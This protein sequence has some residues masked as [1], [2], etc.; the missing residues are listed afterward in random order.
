MS[1]NSPFVVLNLDAHLPND[2]S[3][4]SQFFRCK[5]K[6]NAVDYFNRESANETIEEI[7][8]HNF[9][10]DLNS[11]YMQKKTKKDTEKN[12]V[13][14]A[15]FR[16]GSTRLFNENG[17]LNEKQLQKL[18]TKLRETDS[19]IW[20]AV[21]SFTPEI[22]S[23]I[24]NNPSQAMQLMSEH[25]PA[26]FKDTKIDFENIEW[27]AAFHTNTDYRHIHFFMFEKE[28]KH[29]NTNT[30]KLEYTKTYALPVENLAD[31]KYQIA[32]HIDEK[33]LVSYNLRKETKDAL[34]YKLS[35]DKQFL[36]YLLHNTSDI[37]ENGHFQYN[38]LTS[39]QQNKINQLV[40]ETLQRQPELLKKYNQ[41]LSRLRV[42]QINILNIY[43]D[44]NTV[45]TKAAKNFFT[46]RKKEFDVRLGNTLLKSIKEAYCLQ[47]RYNNFKTNS[48]IF[49]KNKILLCKKKALSIK[50]KEANKLMSLTNSQLARNLDFSLKEDIIS[51]LNKDMSIKESV[52]TMEQFLNEKRQAGE[53][54][55]E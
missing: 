8:Y 6:K 4:K 45:P 12:I 35:D 33:K 20:S 5:S 44:I 3:E 10:D 42:D 49:S 41:Y 1:K 50:G 46:A 29:I 36:Y 30:G 53:G 28:P 38:R 34:A 52:K 19:I 14:Y 37:I 24:C 39:S 47:S 54:V 43:Q 7:E 9:C 18:K 26:L 15:N 23:Q 25:L 16:P 21:V 22:S 27:H 13:N 17:F 51:N 31:F 2:N 55:Y 40:K 32:Q 48:N 11:L